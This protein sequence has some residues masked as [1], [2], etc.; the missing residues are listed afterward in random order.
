MNVTGAED[1]TG[2]KE[3]DEGNAESGS[4]PDSGSGEPE[5]TGG[6][7]AN[8]ALVFLSGMLA[9]LVIGLAVALYV[10]L[11]RRGGAGRVR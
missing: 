11:R 1:T 4:I 3:P 9:M 7:V 8:T 5:E 10:V 2:A 6:S